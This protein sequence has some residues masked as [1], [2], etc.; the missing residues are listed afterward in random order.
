MN[1]KREKLQ[2]VPAVKFVRGDPVTGYCLVTPHLLLTTEQYRK[3]ASAGN[4][5]FAILE[6]KIQLSRVFSYNA[7]EGPDDVIQFVCQSNVD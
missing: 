2:A 7:A 4:K 1:A 5:A 6:S 3:S